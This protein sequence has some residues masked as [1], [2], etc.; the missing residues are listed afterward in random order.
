MPELSATFQIVGIGGISLV[1]GAVGW[2]L[3]AA[4]MAS[5]EV[6]NIQRDVEANTNNLRAVIDEGSKPVRDFMAEER[7]WRR[8]TDRRMDGHSLSIREQTKSIM[9]LT[10]AIASTQ[11]EMKERFARLETLIKKNGHQ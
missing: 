11:T 6:A 9:A 3:R 1:F 4:W 8:D 5:R 2:A 7:Q 10:A